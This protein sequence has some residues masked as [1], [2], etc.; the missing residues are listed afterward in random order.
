VYKL[1]PGEASN[2]K[3]GNTTPNYNVAL[4]GNQLSVSLSSTPAPFDRYLEA[5][6]LDNQW[7]LAIGT[8]AA[9]DTLQIELAAA[10]WTLFVDPSHVGNPHSDGSIPTDGLVGAINSSGYAT[11]VYNDLQAAQNA[12]AHGFDAAGWDVIVPEGNSF[13]MQEFLVYGFSGTTSAPEPSA[14]ILL[15]TI[16]GY[17]GFQKIRRRRVA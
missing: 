12:V 13:P 15:A 11:D 3:Y 9:T 8:S 1:V 14:V 4:V 16:V 2:F 6:W 10:M 5:A 17:L 7:R